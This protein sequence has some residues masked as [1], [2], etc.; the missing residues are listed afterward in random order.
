MEQIS[1]LTDKSFRG[2]MRWFLSEEELD[3]WAK[4]RFGDRTHFVESYATLPSGD[5]VYRNYVLFPDGHY[6]QVFC[7]YKPGELKTREYE[8]IIKSNYAE[9]QAYRRAY[10]NGVQARSS[11]VGRRVIKKS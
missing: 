2:S 4:A 8:Q 5:K 9:I 11:S 7:A 10:S 1:Q 3:E 6:H